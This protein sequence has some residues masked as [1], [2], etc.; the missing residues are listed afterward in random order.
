MS[1]L[2]RWAVRYCQRIIPLTGSCTGERATGA[3]IQCDEYE[4]ACAKDDVSGVLVVSDQSDS[5]SS[6]EGKSSHCSEVSKDGEGSCC[7]LDLV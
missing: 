3:D 7:S 4:S 5:F 2:G 1:K 6:S